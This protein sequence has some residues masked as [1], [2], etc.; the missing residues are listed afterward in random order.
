[1]TPDFSSK[2][3]NTDKTLDLRG[4]LNHILTD[5]SVSP[6]DLA[7]ELGVSA[8]DL[9]AL[10]DGDG[11]EPW[12]AIQGRLIAAL[13]RY[14]LLQD[15]TSVE[16]DISAPSPWL[17]PVPVADEAAVDSDPFGGSAEEI[18]AEDTRTKQE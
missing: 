1:M 8:E 14:G 15:G 6:E 10:L 12:L 3:T 13:K 9:A 16:A 2:F 17:V 18:S 5:Q 11:V 4:A 7:A